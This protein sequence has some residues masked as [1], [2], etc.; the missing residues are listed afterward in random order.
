MSH[1][2]L[3]DLACLENAFQSGATGEK[4]W[5]GGFINRYL[6]IISVCDVCISVLC[7][8]DNLIYR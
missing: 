4:L 2:N 1:L 7:G 8:T 5:E 6:N 3:V